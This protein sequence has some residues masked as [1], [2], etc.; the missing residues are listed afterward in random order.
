M[1]KLR[2][3]LN[4]VENNYVEETTFTSYKND[5]E[6]NDQGIKQRLSQT[7]MTVYGDPENPKST[8][9][10]V[11]QAS[12]LDDQ[13]N[14]QNGIDGR[15]QDAEGT[16]EDTGLNDYD[17]SIKIMQRF[18]NI[19]TDVE[20]IRNVFKVTG[21]R[22][23]IHNSVG[24]F[25]DNTNKPT[26]WDITSGTKYEPFGYDGDLVGAS[27]SRG[28]L[29]CINGKITTSINNITALLVDK[30]LSLS[31]KYKNAANTTSKIKVF[32]GSVIFFEKT[33]SSTVNEWTE[34]TYNPD[35]DPVLANN[36]FLSTVSSLQISIESKYSDASADAKEGFEITDLMLNYGDVKPWELSSNEIYGAMVRLSSLGL[37]VTATTANTKN[38]MTTDGI[39]VY[40]Y[41]PVTDT[42]IGTEPITKITD[43]GT[44]TNMLESTGDIIER[45]LVH[46]MIVD[47][48]NNNVYV[49][50]IRD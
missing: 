21:G 26:L 45:N 32:S 34:Y 4:Y 22:N 6:S 36:S 46:T 3:E 28:R 10:L 48:N 31:F 30:M 15:L 16:L 23:L 37:E 44:L 18:L 38:F 12:R 27:S 43:D 5:M 41:D 9:G 39:L 42:I 13:L 17:K 11:Y 35:T 29:T 25:A 2:E 47:N 1:D 8:E 7:E 50:Y 40:A 24:Y 49:E 20:Q 14:G 33:I 19:E